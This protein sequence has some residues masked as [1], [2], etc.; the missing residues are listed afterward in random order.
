MPLSLITL[1]ERYYA[2]QKLTRLKFNFHSHL[3]VKSITGNKILIPCFNLNLLFLQDPSTYII[4]F[5]G[6]LKSGQVD[7]LVLWNLSFTFKGYECSYFSEVL[8]QFSFFKFLI[9][10]LICYLSLTHSVKPKYKLRNVTT[11]LPFMYSFATKVLRK[12]K[13]TIFK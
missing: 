9:L 6:R 4:T 12:E 3:Q 8:L 10:F 2:P 7:G 5:L 11:R 1:A 13:T